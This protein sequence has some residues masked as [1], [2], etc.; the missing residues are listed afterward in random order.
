MSGQEGGEA[1]SFDAM[2]GGRAFHSGFGRW[3]TSGGGTGGRQSDF[4]APEQGFYSSLV[5]GLADRAV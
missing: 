5:Q 1:A 2:E 3:M 4:A